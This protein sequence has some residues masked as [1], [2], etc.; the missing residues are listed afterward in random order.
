MLVLNIFIINVSIKYFH[1]KCLYYA[2]CTNEYF[3]ET[4]VSVKSRVRREKPKAFRAKKLNIFVIN[5]S[6]G[7]VGSALV[8]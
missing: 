7:A 5:C 3:T 1:H 2:C 4:Y 6:C 8:L